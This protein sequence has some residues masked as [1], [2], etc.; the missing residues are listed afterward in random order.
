MDGGKEIGVGN[1]EG[2]GREGRIREGEGRGVEG[3]KARRK[4]RAERVV[5]MVGRGGEARGGE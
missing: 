3:G 4:G 2:E 5:G 1:V